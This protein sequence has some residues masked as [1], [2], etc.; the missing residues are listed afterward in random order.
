MFGL[1]TAK[2]EDMYNKILLTLDGSSFAEQALPHA[3]RFAKTIDGATLFL[4]G[5]APVVEL[6]S[7][8]T[9]QLYPVYVYDDYLVSQEETAQQLE[10]ALR[11]YLNTIAERLRAEGVQVEVVVRRGAPADE[12]LGFAKEAGMDLIVMSTHGRS[13]IS[14]WVYGSV[15]DKVLRSATQPVLLIRAQEEPQPAGGEDG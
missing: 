7:V 13:G 5:I 15:A 8:A 1:K 12:I 9:T 3:R 14:R 6:Q 10:D 4:L 11:D 2:E